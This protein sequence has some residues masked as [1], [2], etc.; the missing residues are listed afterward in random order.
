MG[1]WVSQ[2]MQGMLRE[3]GAVPVLALRTEPL[4]PELAAIAGGDR[5]Q[6]AKIQAQALRDNGYSVVEVVLR[7]NDD[8]IDAAIK[9]VFRIRKVL[10]MCV[11][12]GTVLNREMAIELFKVGES[13]KPSGIVGPNF[14]PGVA[15]VC[16]AH[17]V[18]Y[19]PGCETVSEV[20]QAWNCGCNVVK[21]YPWNQMGADKLKS[22]WDVM[23]GRVQYMPTGG[24]KLD[25]FKHV[26]GMRG[27]L[28]VGG[29][30]YFT[31]PRPEAVAEV[32]QKVRAQM[33]AYR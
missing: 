26:L 32:A 22:I 29:S 18:P 9:A 20:V 11:L 31:D 15:E 21:L 13:G 1:L 33:S 27:V 19:I 16:R 5:I 12:A 14:S 28:C 7:G 2:E 6:L 17:N 23:G 4:T 8:D 25:T 10:N 3:T 24:I 30:F